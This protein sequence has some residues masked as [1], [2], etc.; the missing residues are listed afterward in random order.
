M[1]LNKPIRQIQELLGGHDTFMAAYADFLK[2]DNVPRS[3]VE[4]LHRLEQNTQQPPEDDNSQVGLYVPICT[5]AV[6]LSHHYSKNMIKIP[7]NQLERLRS[8]C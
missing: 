8:G 2:S 6:Y 1:L 7:S 3:L 4:D 5:I